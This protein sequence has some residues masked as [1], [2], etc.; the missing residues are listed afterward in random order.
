[1]KL[2]IFLLFIAAVLRAE[3]N[4]C[5]SFYTLSILKTTHPILSFP[6]AVTYDIHALAN[7]WKNPFSLG[8]KINF[9]TQVYSRFS[10]TRLRENPQTGQLP[11]QIHNENYLYQLGTSP[12]VSLP[13][14]YQQRDQSLSQI[15]S[16]YLRQGPERRD[17]V[18]TYQ[19]EDIEFRDRTTHFLLHEDNKTVGRIQLQHSLHPDQ[20]LNVES[21]FPE[22]AS[23]AIRKGKETIFFELG[24]L[25][26]PEPKN[27]GQG[28][29]GS[30][31]R[32]LAFYELF[33]RPFMYIAKT[34]PE[35]AIVMQTNALVLNRIRKGF[36]PYKLTD[37]TIISK[38][39]E[40]H[41]Y[42]TII[43]SSEI[44]TA[45]KILFLKRLQL[46]LE[47]YLKSNFG[48]FRM[49]IHPDEKPFYDELDT[50]SLATTWLQ[51]NYEPIWREHL[52]KSLQKKLGSN[53]SDVKTQI[54]FSLDSSQFLNPH[55]ISLGLSE[56]KILLQRI[57]S[58]ISELDQ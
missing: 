36:A 51:Q 26:I 21:H 12:M 32:T 3:S 30:F 1:M 39:G 10:V 8:N 24:R 57:Q 38:P 13:F 19:N 27:D 2:A 35:A 7:S 49:T 48:E 9:N 28:L 58:Q 22:V 56:S 44:R 45:T 55:F 42:L 20:K 25:H 15:Y 37:V 41:E 17:H 40:P 34:S 31:D 46:I 11:Q 53:F 23:T 29:T 52:N 33:L 16:N 43:H 6:E 47:S 54:S 18:R 50:E 14:L 4:R 5:L